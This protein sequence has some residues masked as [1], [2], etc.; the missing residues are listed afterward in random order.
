MNLAVCAYIFKTHFDPPGWKGSHCERRVLPLSFSL[1]PF[2]YFLLLP[3]AFFLF[4]L[5]LSSFFLIDTDHTRLPSIYSSESNVLLFHTEV[6]SKR[7][8]KL[9]LTVVSF[10]CGK[11][12]E[13]E[14]TTSEFGRARYSYLLSEPI[15]TFLRTRNT[16]IIYPL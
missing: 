4:L 11:R 15:K 12:E 5:S 8:G 16:P 9:I 14:E 2:L 3:P 10:L 6:T 13:D 7:S 1:L